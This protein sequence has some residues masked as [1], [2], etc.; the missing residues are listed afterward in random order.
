[1]M[2][3]TLAGTLAILTVATC[4]V[5]P[6]RA[7]SPAKRLESAVKLLRSQ[8]KQAKAQLRSLADEL[9]RSTRKRPKSAELFFLRGRALFHVAQDNAALS[10]FDQAITLR[11]KRAKFHYWRGVVLRYRRDPAQ[12]LAALSK[13]LKLTPKRNKKARA[14]VLYELGDVR[15]NAKE[16]AA[17]LRLFERAIRL[18]PKHARALFKAGVLLARG[19]KK[20][21]ALRY[22]RR[23]VAANPRYIAAHYNLGQSFQLAGKHKRALSHFAQ[24]VALA[25]NDWR[26]R[27]KLV[28]L[29]QALG[30]RKAR[31]KARATLMAQHKS[32]KVAKLARAKTYCRDQFVVSGTRVY[33]Y[34]HFALVGPRAKRY[35]FFVGKGSGRYTVSLGSYPATNAMARESGRLRPGQRR[36]HLDGY[37]PGGKHR[38]FGFFNGEPSYEA[39][40]KRVIA[41]VKRRP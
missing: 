24:V 3:T 37:Y 23:A 1:M 17:A 34:E 40:K 10:A 8:P 19:G 7:Q 36:F 9:A 20:K 4:A 15:Y 5:S 16:G 39:I 41:I 2:R 30:Q 35:S 32:G 28:Q 14:R 33:A 25:P 13:A 38:T 22:W 6:A 11:P 18:D 29:H 21:T 26:A 12:S 27:S 31:D